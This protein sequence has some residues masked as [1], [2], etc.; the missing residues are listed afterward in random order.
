MSGERTPLLQ[1]VHVSDLHL[2]DSA[3]ETTG[4]MRRAAGLLDM[5]AT[6]SGWIPALREYA[7]SYY[8]G[9]LGHAEG[10]ERDFI[11]FL[12]ALRGE[13]S[14]WSSTETWLVDTGDLTTWGDDS[15]L[16]FGH[17]FFEGLF[18]A[19]LV[20]EI[21]SIYGNHDAW[22]GSQPLLCSQSTNNRHRTNLRNVWYTDRYPSRVLSK[23][24]RYRDGDVVLTMLNSV[25]HERLRNGLAR[26]EINHD[27]WWETE[28]EP[29]ELQ[30]MTELAKLMRE[31]ARTDRHLFSIAAVH[32]PVYDPYT[33]VDASTMLLDNRQAVCDMMR[34]FEKLETYPMVNLFLSGHVHETFPEVGNFPTQLGGCGHGFL[35]DSQAQLITGT[36]LKETDPRNSREDGLSRVLPWQFQVLRLYETPDVIEVERTVVGR[37]DGLRFLPVPVDATGQVSETLSVH[38]PLRGKS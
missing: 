4:T 33:A 25:L 37:D 2:V 36:L 1:I 10:S 23:A 12:R 15:S 7:A 30:Q 5:L 21:A 22:P 19:G 24:M 14:E 8:D 13:E 18:R 16:Q 11:D 6:K 34:A 26:G 28:H 35:C 17:E 29:I 32:H 20:D 27:R 9:L 3:F 31:R 38:Y